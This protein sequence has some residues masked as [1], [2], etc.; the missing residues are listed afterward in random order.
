MRTARWLAFAVHR[1]RLVSLLAKALEPVT[2][3]SVSHGDL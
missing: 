2:M 1:P 3:E